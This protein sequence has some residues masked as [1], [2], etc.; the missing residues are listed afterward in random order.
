MQYFGDPHEIKPSCL[1]AIAHIKKKKK[2]KTKTSVA[3]MTLL[4]CIFFSLKG[5]QHSK[6]M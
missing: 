4:V 2:P 5:L 1:E 6:L 3:L